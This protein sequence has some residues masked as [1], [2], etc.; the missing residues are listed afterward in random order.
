MPASDEHPFKVSVPDSD[1]EL[2]HKKLELATL[3]DELE[4]AHWNYGVPLA[5]VK[6]LLARWKDGFDWRKAEAEINIFPQFTRDIEVDGFGTLNIHYV[7]QRS[8]V[9][10]SIPLLFIHGWPGHFMEAKKLIPLLT[11]TSPDHPTFHVVAISLPGYGFS[12]A[13]KKKGFTVAQYAEAANKLMLSLGYDQFVVQGGDWGHFVGKQ[14]ACTYANR[15]VKAFHTNIAVT[16]FPSLLS[17]PLIFLTALIK[18]WTAAE[19]VGIERTQSHRKY[20]W[21]YFDIQST[22][23]QTLGYGLADSPV[24]LL[25]WIYEKLVTWTDDYPW[26]DDEVLTWVSIYWFSRAGPAASLRIYYEI[27]QSG[28]LDRIPNLWAPVPVGFS[29][30]PKDIV[31]LPTLWARCMGNVVHVSEHER[32]GHFAAF[33]RPEDLAGDLR[34]MFITKGPAFGVVDGRTGYA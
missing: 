13:P 5:R 31:V 7:H 32:G 34:N 33:E 16:G 19:R 14:M 30:F 17:A 28:D 20:G 22:R 15:S 27:T 8:N 3:P 1:L 18:P 12:E 10:D 21:G 9:E 6:Q 25:A 23:P 24:G 26:E 2:L 11:S 29:S 4:E